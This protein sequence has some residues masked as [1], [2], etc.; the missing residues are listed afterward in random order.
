MAQEASA[1]PAARRREDRI[2]GGI[3]AENGGDTGF[4]RGCYGFET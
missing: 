4:R 2:M 3:L 1:K